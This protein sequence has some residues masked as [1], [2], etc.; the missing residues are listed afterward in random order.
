MNENKKIVIAG[1]GFSGSYFARNLAEM[2]WDVKVVEKH[3]H[4]AGHVYDKVDEETGCMVHEFGPHIFH[5]DDEDI[6]SWVTRFAEFAPFSLKTQ[7]FFESYQEWFVCSFGFHTIEQLF[8]EE[9]AA[10]T[11]KRLKDNYPGRETVTVPELLNSK[12]EYIK[13]FADILWA[14][15]YRPYTAK[16]WGL[17]PTKVDPDI[18]KRVPVYMSY[19]DK[20]HDDKYEAV[21]V[22]GYTEL[23]KN[24]LDH[25]NIELQLNTDALEHLEIKDNQAYYE[26][27]KTIFLFTGAIDDLF[28]YEFG[29]LNYRSL[30][31]EREIT[32]NDKN[33]QVGEPCVDIYPDEK[34][35]FTRITNYGKLPI[36]NDI[37][38]Q[39]SVKEYPVQYELGSG[40]DRFY[41]VSTEEDKKKF[42]KYKEKADKI[43]GLFLS[44]RL[45]NYKYYDMDKSLI[46]AREALQEFLMTVEK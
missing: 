1:A 36:Q 25:E 7:V 35:E 8:D 28:E 10:E 46:A 31:F 33:T 45:A 44:G 19:F 42:A 24:I 17:E 15:D 14:E 9:K 26:G 6:W 13:E 11:I 43:D 32:A 30:I 29:P 3:D 12:D 18:L 41:P 23:F 27:E 4:V 40:I 22:D 38:Y 16:Q 37:E 2:G 34:Y 39:I 21:P 5:T 20:I